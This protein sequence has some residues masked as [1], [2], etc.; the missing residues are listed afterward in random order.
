MTKNNIKPVLVLTVICLVVAVLLSVVNMF[1]APEIKRKEEIAIQESLSKVLPENSGFEEVKP[2][3]ELPGTVNSVWRDKGGA[4]FVVTLKTKTNYTKAED[5]AISVGI[6]SEGK[7][8]GVVLT[9][10]SE[11]KD[12]G[13]DYPGKFVGLD[14]SGADG[15]D[16]VAGVTYSSN[17]FKAA[18]ADAFA[19][20]G[21]LSGVKEDP[22]NEAKMLAE[23]VK[24]M[25]ETAALEKVELE[26]LPESVKLVF[27]DRH[28]QGSVVLVKTKTQYVDPDTV[29]L[30]SVDHAGKVREVKI[31]EWK[32]GEG[33]TYT[34]DFVS[35]FTG[36][37]SAGVDGV[38]VIAGSTGTSTNLKLAVKDAITAA[39]AAEE[40]NI[41]AAAELL[42]GATELV[43]VAPNVWRDKGGA[44][45]VCIIES[46][47]QY[48]K[49]DTV[50]MIALDAEK[51]V[52]GIEILK[53]VHGEGIS[54]TEEF[55]DA[56]LGKNY[57]SV[58]SVEAIAGATGTSDNVKGAV[59][60]AIKYIDMFLK[61][62]GGNEE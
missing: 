14:T 30:V 4:G 60:N 5:M 7:I 10:Y 6:S 17:A 32:H 40:A 47:T 57:E 42:P 19:V 52:V 49:P 43:S 41:K 33:Y 22:Y 58:D 12:F 29:S 28:G 20:V 59:K 21:M 48:V 56:F 55:E 34:E 18:I 54:F 15:I 38:D 37:D 51:N 26:N 1:T 39:R 61:G 2:E 62:E 35:S 11:S 27:K 44:G 24:M 9:A 50:T 8:T 46:E 25:P 23:A 36:L 53:W 3:G 13:S 16:A 45:F 31:L